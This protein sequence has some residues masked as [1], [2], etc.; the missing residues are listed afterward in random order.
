LV[1]LE[2]LKLGQLLLLRLFQF[3]FG[4]I[5][6]PSGEWGSSRVNWF[7]FHF[8]TIRSWEV[9]GAVTASYEFQFH[10]GTIRSLFNSA[11]FSA[12]SGFNSTLVRLEGC[13][14]SELFEIERVSIPLWYD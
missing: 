11:P 1:R 5:R 4:T 13:R 3:H 10:F 9:T 6:R 8:G 7:Q 12:M 2:V 14:V